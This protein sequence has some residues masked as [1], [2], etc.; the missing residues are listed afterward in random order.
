MTPASSRRLKRV[1]GFF[2]GSATRWLCLGVATAAL[3]RKMP[4]FMHGIA[5]LSACMIVVFWGIQVVAGLSYFSLT[6]GHSAFESDEA[7]VHRQ[8]R[9]PFERVA[10]DIWGL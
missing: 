6:S 4:A 10:A 2:V 8:G 9:E 3:R 5:R 1:A 7:A